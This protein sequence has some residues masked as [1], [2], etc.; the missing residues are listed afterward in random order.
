MMLTGKFC[1]RGHSFA[2]VGQNKWGNCKACRVILNRSISIKRFSGMS[3]EQFDEMY[4]KQ[5]GC[6]AICGKHQSLFKRRLDIDHC[7]KTGKVRGL[8]CA[9]CNAQVIVT[10]EV[11]GH[12]IER[13]KTYLQETL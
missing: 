2:L 4:I 13:A 5:K 12:L 3:V 6:C 8:L 7:H 10:V 11:Y 9:T 1:K